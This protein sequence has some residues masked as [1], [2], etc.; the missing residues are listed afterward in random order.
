MTVPLLH[1]RILEDRKELSDRQAVIW[2]GGHLTHGQL[3][4]RSLRLAGVLSHYGIGHGDRVAICIPKSPEAV[5]GILATLS[6]GA[7]YVP[8][9]HDSPPR[10]ILEVLED[11]EPSVTLTTSSVIDSLKSSLHEEKIP[12]AHR[13]LR[14]LS[15][16]V[17]IDEKIVDYDHISQVEGSESKPENPKPSLD[18]LAAILFTS[19]SSGRPKGVQLTHGNIS[20]FVQWAIY[21]FQLQSKDRFANHAPLHFDLSTLDLFASLDVGASV[22]LL[23]AKAVLFP[24][25]I[26][27]L[28]EEEKI[29]IW[30]SVPT[31]LRMLCEY[32]ALE[33]RDMRNLRLVFFAGEVLPVPTLR[34][35]MQKLT[36][37][38][39]V[40]FYGPTETNVCTYHVVDEVPTVTQTAIPVGIPCEHL[41]VDVYLDDGSLARPDEVGEICVFGANVTPGYWCNEQLSKSV[42]LGKRQDS[43]LT[44]DLGHRDGEGQIW[45]HGRNDHQIQ[46]RGHRLE[47]S[48]V[49]AHLIRHPFVSEAVVCMTQTSTGQSKLIAF[50]RPLKNEIPSEETLRKHCE[51][52][53]PHY[54]VPSLYCVRHNLPLSSNGKI[55]RS[56]LLK[57]LP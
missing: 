19:G 54:A 23:D 36:S 24:S 16:F 39:F 43:Y 29:T 33:Q 55:S 4:T 8:I 5:Q 27:K 18:D 13:E 49:E 31:A 17:T 7:A 50:V 20:S 48:A 30:Y 38:K 22:F 21:R 42:R 40:N 11:A 2:D 46:F 28:I 10:R 1:E 53:L 44:G 35:L 3:R 9:D 51:H 26:A 57:T 6:L 47:L 56:E 15:R 12:D 25:V 34:S 45:F 14:Q 37:A 32:G 52:R 41:E